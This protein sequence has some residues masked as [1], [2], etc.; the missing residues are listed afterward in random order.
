MVAFLV[1]LAMGA[2]LTSCRESL[3][4]PEPGSVGGAPVA[5]NGSRD[6]HAP[7]VRGFSL[8]QHHR[9]SRIRIDL[10]P[11]PSGGRLRCD[12]APVSGLSWSFRLS[13]FPEARGDLTAFDVPTIVVEPRSADQL[14]VRA[15]DELGGI[16]IGTVGYS[17]NPSGL[18]F[19]LPAEW[20]QDADGLV[21]WQV[22]MTELEA[23]PKGPSVRWTSRFTGNNAGLEGLA[24]R[25]P[26]ITRLD[27]RVRGDHLEIEAHVIPRHQGA[28]LSFDPTVEGG[29]AL[30]LF[31]NT[32]R[33]PTGYWMGF[34][35]VVRGTELVSMNEMQVRLTTGDCGCPGGWG[36]ATGTAP[37]RDQSRVMD[38]SI[39]LAALG[40]DD[41]AVDYAFETYATVACAECPG[42]VAQIYFDDYFG[43]TGAGAPPAPLIAS[44]PPGSM[45]QRR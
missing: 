7:L 23:G 11:D 40:D 28:N 18:R 27:A 8:K 25:V 3:L 5:T 29:W 26:L 21:T 35:Y 10:V 4:R 12:P 31:V 30:Q 45:A 44:A 33:G 19:D 2:C 13:I 42:G 9:E 24:S 22:D 37:F 43:S 16:E 34:D 38:I 36:P 20:L 6:R 39:P 41:G 1:I 17:V 14:L 15:P 32:D